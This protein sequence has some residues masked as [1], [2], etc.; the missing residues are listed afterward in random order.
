[1]VHYYVFRIATT[2][3]LMAIYLYPVRVRGTT[4]QQTIAFP[5][6][7]LQEVAFFYP[8]PDIVDGQSHLQQG[9]GIAL[10]PSLMTINTNHMP[11]IYQL[12]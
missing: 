12:F 1:M 9:S 4:S 5:P 6:L 2:I 10:K 3:T 8:K 7:V 11:V